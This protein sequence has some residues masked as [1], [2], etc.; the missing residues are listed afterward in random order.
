MARI[1]LRAVRQRNKGKKWDR[2]YRRLYPNDCVVHTNNP[3]L[4]SGGIDL[5][6]HEGVKP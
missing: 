4:L 2:Q 5:R 3:A 6:S 1:F